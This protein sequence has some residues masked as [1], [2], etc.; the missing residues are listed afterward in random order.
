MGNM[1]H[2]RRTLLSNDHVRPS[3][4]DGANRF[5]VPGFPNLRVVDDD[6]A[7]FAIG[8]TRAFADHAAM[9]KAL[10]ARAYLRRKSPKS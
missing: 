9:A 1:S 8:G 5:D 6:A 2:R 3:T 7:P 10:Y 4:G